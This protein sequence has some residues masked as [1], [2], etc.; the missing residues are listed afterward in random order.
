MPATMTGA[1][2]TP[3]GEVNVLFSTLPLDVRGMFSTVADAAGAL[4]AQ[5]TFPAEGD[6][7]REGEDRETVFVSASDVTR[8]QANQQPPES[9]F[10]ATELTFTRWAGYSPG[11]YVPGRRVA[12][13]AY[14]WAFAAG[15]TAWLLFRKGSRTAASVKLGQLDAVCGDLKARVRVPA[16]LEAGRYRVVL[17][18]DRRRPSD[19]HT[20]RIARVTARRSAWIRTAAAQTPHHMRAAPAGPRAFA[21]G[22]RG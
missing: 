4:S 19:W 21:S 17:S 2:Y 22:R 9:Q 7:L 11:R 8:M 13:E 14:G 15:E 6:F 10:A 16:R 5:V 12:V 3:G 1:N 18:T 20:W